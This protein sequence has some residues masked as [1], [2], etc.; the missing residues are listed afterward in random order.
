MLKNKPYRVS[1]HFQKGSKAFVTSRL[2]H[3]FLIP[4]QEGSQISVDLEWFFHV[5]TFTAT[6]SQSLLIHPRCLKWG[7]FHLNQASSKWLPHHGVQEQQKALLS[8]DLL[9]NLWV[10]TALCW[11]SA[12]LIRSSFTESSVPNITKCITI[13]RSFQYDGEPRDAHACNFHTTHLFTL[14]TGPA[15]NSQCSSIKKEWRTCKTAASKH[16]WGQVFP[17]SNRTFPTETKLKCYMFVGFAE[18]QRKN[19]LLCYYNHVSRIWTDP[20]AKW[21]RLVQSHQ[22][23]NI[24]RSV[25]PNFKKFG[26]PVLRVSHWHRHLS[27]ELALFLNADFTET[28]SNGTPGPRS[29]PRNHEQG[30][31]CINQN[32]ARHMRRQML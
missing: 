14:S 20:A 15:P 16:S 28:N 5:S 7:R 30:L 12:A 3:S 26:A 17:M 18:Q 25:L 24:D 31:G 2:T 4:G 21:E 32:T 19:E 27:Q 22:L 13:R 6:R 29:L 23:E 1:G 11:G 9:L 8:P 10:G